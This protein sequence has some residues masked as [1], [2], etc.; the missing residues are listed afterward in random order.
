MKKALAS[1][2][3]D[4]EQSEKVNYCT[5][6]ELFDLLDAAEADSMASERT[7]RGYKVKVRFKAGKPEEK[8]QKR[9]AVS[10]VIVKAMKRLRSGT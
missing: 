7:V 2:S 8:E 3:L 6:E 5:P 10:A 1:S 4:K 9:G